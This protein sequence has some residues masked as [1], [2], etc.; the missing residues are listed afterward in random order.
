MYLRGFVG[1]CYEEG[2]W[3]PLKNSAFGGENAGMMGWLKKQGGSIQQAS[4]S[5]MP[6]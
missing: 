5:P 1:G 2:I 6:V 3:T 4:I